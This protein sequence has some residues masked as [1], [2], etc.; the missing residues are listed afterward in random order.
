MALAARQ[1]GVACAHELRGRAEYV[2]TKVGASDAP[3][4][5]VL[6]RWPILRADEGSFAH[7]I[8]NGLLLERRAVQEYRDRRCEFRLAACQLDRFAEC[9]DMS[10]HRPSQYTSPLVCVNKPARMT[11]DKPPCT[12]Q[13]MAKK[14]APLS[15]VVRVRVARAIG[16]DERTLGQRVRLAMER[17]RPPLSESDLVAACSDWKDKSGRALVSQ[18]LVNQILK[19]KNSRSAITPLLA[20]ALGVRATWLQFGIGDVSEK[21]SSGR[22][23]MSHQDRA[24]RAFMQAFRE[25]PKEWEF[26][27]RGIVGTLAVA[28]RESHGEFAARAREKT[29]ELI[30]NYSA[31]QDD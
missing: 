25:L 12:V 24:D 4:G 14:T 7:P 20:E 1:N 10:F 26:T 30:Q 2:W 16:D 29:R 15:G 8:R 5:G 23:P 22:G 28:M 6:Y 18:Q 9:F 11:F 31:V 21:P 19:D 13:A 3:T 17:H 27:I